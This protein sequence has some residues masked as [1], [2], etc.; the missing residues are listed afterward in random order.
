VRHLFHSWPQVIHRIEAKSTIALFLDFDGTLVPIQARP[1]DVWLDDAT[2]RTL[3]RLARSPRFR[4][5]IVTGRRRADVRARV[6]VSGIHY[7]GLHGWEGRA[8]GAITEE[9]REAV[10]CAKSWLACLLLSVPGVWLEDKGLTLAIHYQSVT[11]EGVR[12]ARKFVEGVLASFDDTLQLIRGKKVW[13]LAPRELGDKGVAVASELPAAGSSAVPV[14][15][16]DDLMD[17]PAFCALSCGV[18]VRVG[19]PCRTHARYRLS[20]VEQVHQFLEKLEGEFA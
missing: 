15:I 18:T 6:R 17:E 20:S 4:V 19:R 12:K 3:S 13:E 9:A 16:G 5:W 8:A 1:E 7:L 14:F 10:A 11:E 2:R